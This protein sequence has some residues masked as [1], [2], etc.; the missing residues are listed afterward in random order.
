MIN[1]LIKNKDYKYS[2]PYGHYAQ[3]QIEILKGAYKGLVF[4][5]ED[6]GVADRG[7]FSKSLRVTYTLQKPWKSAQVNNNTVTLTK[8]DENFICNAVYNFV[9][10]FHREQTIKG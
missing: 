5:I 1:L 3:P 8:E 9:R 6:S 7:L 2:F 10:D 4:D